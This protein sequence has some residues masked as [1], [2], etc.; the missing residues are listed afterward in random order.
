VPRTLEQVAAELVAELVRRTEVRV[1]GL[2]RD[3]WRLADAGCHPASRPQP[4]HRPLT[5]GAAEWPSRVR[6]CAGGA[7]ESALLQASVES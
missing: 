7:A 3:V 5:K 6:A 1:E 4:S 2:F